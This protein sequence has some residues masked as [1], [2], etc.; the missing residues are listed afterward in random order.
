MVNSP[1]AL[2]AVRT[3]RQSG[4]ALELGWHP[5][6]TMDPPAAGAERV[7]SLVG[8]DGC[9]WPLGRFLKRLITGRIRAE[10]IELEL[11]AQYEHFVEWIGGPPMVVNVHQHVGLFSPVG[12]LLRQVLAHSRPLPYVRRIIEPATMLARIPGARLKRSVLTCLGRQTGSRPKARGLSRRG[13]PGRYNR[14]EMGP[15]PGVL[16]PL[17]VASSGPGGRI[18]L[19]SRPSRTPHCQ[20]ATATAFSVAVW[21]NTV[22]WRTPSFDEACRRAGFTRVTPSD[23]AAE[24]HR[25]CQEAERMTVKDWTRF[26]GRDSWARVAVI[27]W[28]LILGIIAVRAVLQPDSHDCYKP[29]YEPAGR[30]WLHG[31]DL[32]QL[33]S[34]PAV[35]ARSSTP[36]SRIGAP[37]DAGRRHD[38][39]GGQRG[40]LLGRSVLVAARLRAA[41]VD[42]QPLGL[43]LPSRDTAGGPHHQFR[44]GES[45]ADRP[46]SGRHGR[47]G[48]RAWNW[49]AIFIAGAFFLKIYPIA[50]A[51]LLIVTFPRRFTPRFL[52]ALAVGAALP[53]FMQNPWWVAR[54]HVNWWTSLCIDDRTQW[55]PE[56]GYRDLWLLIRFYKLPI[57]YSG[58]VVIQLAIAGAAAAVCM[59]SRWRAGRPR[60][61][62]LNTAM[63]LAVC[64]MTVCGPTTEGSGY[65]LV[66]PTLA[67]AFLESWHLPRPS[68]I[69][70][71]LL[72][73][74]VAFTVAV[75][76]CLT[77][78][79]SEG[80]A[81]G[82]HPLGGLLLMI[83]VAGEAIRRILAPP[84]ENIGTAPTR[85]GEHVATLAPPPQGR[86]GRG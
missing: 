45:V 55:A 68:W 59:A 23:W 26:G 50:L 37:A 10:E 36:C 62:V 47:C 9:M 70:G 11:A 86:V 58:Y 80:M 76:A 84:A 77:S 25:A 8:P 71:L 38:L 75:L 66:A 49:A 65:I 67:F 41:D 32:Y 22:C 78:R 44:P 42:A 18:R 43:G 30:N 40:R 64:W 83:A 27:A 28:T 53:F 31:E 14:S 56:I 29:F 21:T 54:Q 57:R 46:H 61:E 34:I 16:R 63:A 51:L 7:P 60:L 24:R 13:L 2:E 17:A 79:P 72:A 20:A 81:Y 3:W 15:R 6:L 85:A 69:R 4:K 52:V 73:S 33:K 19:S 5:C 1:Y 12:V 35:T 74:T 39:A 82:P 48:A